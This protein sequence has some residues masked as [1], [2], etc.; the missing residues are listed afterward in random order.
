MEH[1]K[2]FREHFKIIYCLVMKYR[3]AALKDLLIR[4]FQSVNLE[5]KV[6]F[7]FVRMGVMTSN[8]SHSFFV[9]KD[10]NV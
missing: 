7:I 4:F 3:T 2:F 6:P 1:T 10:S 5:L 8:F 9:A